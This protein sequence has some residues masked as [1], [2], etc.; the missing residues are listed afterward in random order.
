MFGAL[1]SVVGAKMRQEFTK[2]EDL[3]KMLYAIAEKVKA[4]KDREV[5]TGTL[6]YCRCA[7]LILFKILIY[8]RISFVMVQNYDSFTRRYIVLYA[9]INHLHV[10][11]I[12]KYENN[13]LF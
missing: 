10:Y 13:F 9:C 8:S 1:L 7:Y 12:D 6:F 5:S 11:I 4:A 2:Q 3:V